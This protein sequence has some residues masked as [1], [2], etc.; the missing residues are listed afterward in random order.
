MPLEER[1]R[2]DDHESFT[3]IEKL[4]QTTDLAS[5]ASF[6]AAPGF[7]IDLVFELQPL[8]F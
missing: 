4:E 7:P 2:L 8:R 1:L 6:T 5:V 3:P